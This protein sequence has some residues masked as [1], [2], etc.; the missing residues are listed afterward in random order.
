MG[1]MVNPPHHSAEQERIRSVYRAWQMQAHVAAYA[2]HRP[3]ILEQ[4]AARMRVGAAMLADTVGPDLSQLDIVDV[5]CGAGGFLRQLINWGADPARLLGTE[6]QAD[7]LELARSRSAAGVRWHL[8]ELDVLEAGSVDL[9]IANTVFSSI[10]ASSL[11]ADL[12]ASMWRVLAPGGWIMLFD[13][14]YN[15]PNNAQVRKVGRAELR[16]W[17]PAAESR[18]RTLL[19]APPI[20]RRLVAA[21]RLV[22]DMLTSFVPPLRSHFIYMARKPW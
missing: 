6:Y 17:W 18:Y 11:R 5:G 12:A 7:R 16:A 21:P 9:A 8:G 20:G 2:W 13:F 3:D 14:R 22:V 15:N 4:D 1:D 10:L 19:L